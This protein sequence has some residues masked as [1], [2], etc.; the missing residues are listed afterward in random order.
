MHHHLEVVMPPTSDVKGAVASIL[1][2]FCEHEPTDES[3]REDWRPKGTFW[4]YF[5]VGGRWAG[6]KK[7]ARYGKERIDEF[8][9]WCR[10]EKVTV[11][12][13]QSG[14]QTLSPISQRGKVDAKWA[15]MFGD[16]VCPL[17]DHANDQ[18]GLRGDSALDGDVA[19][20]GDVPDTMECARII[21]AGPSYNH[22]TGQFD[23]K[24]TAVFMLAE[25]AWN[26]VN[27]MPVTWDGTLRDALAQFTEKYQTYRDDYKAR[28]TPTAD[29]LVVTVDYHS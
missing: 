11:S 28:I 13:V 26:G 9:A 8:Y 5:V 2:P 19:K 18:L 27:Y 25:D 20:F 29:W 1:A 10:D 3:D 12:G 22:E 23:G 17:F 16:A 6:D 7:L 21:F 15:E 14:K 4:D 24:A